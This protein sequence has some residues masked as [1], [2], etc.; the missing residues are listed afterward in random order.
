MNSRCAVNGF[1]IESFA[2]LRY[3]YLKSSGYE[4]MA[5]SINGGGALPGHFFRDQPQGY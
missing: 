1:E 2:R 4:E 5:D 3:L